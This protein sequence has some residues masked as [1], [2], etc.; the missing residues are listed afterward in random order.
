MPRLLF[1]GRVG[2]ELDEQLLDTHLSG[3]SWP[4]VPRSRCMW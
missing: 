2:P 3:C 4:P 1:S